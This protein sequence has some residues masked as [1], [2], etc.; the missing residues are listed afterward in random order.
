ML[1]KT[2]TA[3]TALSSMDAAVTSRSMTGKLKRL[4][5]C[6]FIHL[7]Q[8]CLV[9]ANT[10]KIQ[11]FLRQ[12]NWAGRIELEDLR[13]HSPM[14]YAHVNPYVRFELNMETRLPMD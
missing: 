10:L 12:P 5:C 14:I 4:L 6:H 13:A 11:H 2:G 1:L 9:Y 3:P 7:L 8:V